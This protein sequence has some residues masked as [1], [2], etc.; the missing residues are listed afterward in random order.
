MEFTN[1]V[2]KSEISTL[3]GS[4]VHAVEV[5]YDGVNQAMV[6]QDE[7]TE[8]ILSD[9]QTFAEFLVLTIILNQH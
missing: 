2:C 8:F 3:Y 9:T 7:C 1:G 4:V 6:M 5:Q